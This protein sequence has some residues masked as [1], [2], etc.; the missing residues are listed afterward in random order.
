MDTLSRLNDVFREVFDDDEI[1]ITRGTTAQ[2]IEG[3]D[4]VMHVT[5]MINVEKAFGVKFRSS[6]V[7]D[8]K[9]VGDLVD[10]IS[11]RAG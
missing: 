7:A 11:A 4:S 8:L 6:D 3:W 2:D 5:L 10:L 1:S 9:S